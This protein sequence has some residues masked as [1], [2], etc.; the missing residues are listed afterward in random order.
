MRRSR[1]NPTRAPL[2]RTELQDTS[3]AKSK[4]RAEDVERVCSPHS[5]TDFFMVCLFLSVGWLLSRCHRV[6]LPGARPQHLRAD[7][8]N[9]RRRRWQ[10]PAASTSIERIEIASNDRTWLLSPTR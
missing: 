3:E 2:S 1:S 8:Y 5:Y 6:V 7:V 10:T 4:S 9:K